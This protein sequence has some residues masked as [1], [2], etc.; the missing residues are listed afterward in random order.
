[1]KEELKS[2]T[3]KEILAYSIVA[4]SVSR[5][6]Y[7]NFADS[8]V[9]ELQKGRFKSL[10][11]DEVM[12][13]EELEKIYHKEFGKGDIE[14]PKGK[15]LPPHEEEIDVSTAENMVQSLEWARQN[16]LNAYDIYKY[17]AEEHDMYRD[18]FEYLA[19]MEWGHY[20]SLKAEMDFY[21]GEIE[22]NPE[23]K[24][25]NPWDIGREEG[26]L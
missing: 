24:T 26:K 4:E 3:F 9:G 16:E 5:K 2:L 18:I 20:E 15:D 22:Q 23:V 7:L 8:A 14:Y 19:L 25:M 12:H 21:K 10:A 17:L 13:S 1:M 11:K 6:T